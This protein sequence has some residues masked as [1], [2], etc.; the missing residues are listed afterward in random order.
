MLFGVF[1]MQVDNVAFVLKDNQGQ[2]AK[3]RFPFKGAAYKLVEKM[4]KTL[5]RKSDNPQWKDKPPMTKWKIGKDD[6]IEF[7]VLEGEEE[8]KFLTW[9]KT[10]IRNRRYAFSCAI[11]FQ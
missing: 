10:D 4:H 9:C 8:E 3:V 11:I 2:S 6:Q 7:S 1:V 5:A